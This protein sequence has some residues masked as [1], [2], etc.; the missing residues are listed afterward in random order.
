MS[1]TV[2]KSVDT[3]TPLLERL[4]TLPIFELFYK[5][6]SMGNRQRFYAKDKETAMEMGREWC[7]EFGFHFINVF[8]FT[9]D[10]AE[11]IVNHRLKNARL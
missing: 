3:P 11:A 8:P 7:K 4:N 10:F 2:T 5:T 9:V 6:G 1:T